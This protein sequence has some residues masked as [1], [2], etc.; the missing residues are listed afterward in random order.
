MH[1]VIVMIAAL[2]LILALDEF[3]SAVVYV[4]IGSE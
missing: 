1:P 2:V 3:L 4:I